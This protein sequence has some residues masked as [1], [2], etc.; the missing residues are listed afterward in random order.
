MGCL[1]CNIIEGKTPSKKVYE[2]DTVYAFED[3][4]PQAPVHVLVVHKRHTRSIDEI[5]EGNSSI[6]SDLFLAVKEVAR[7]TG[8]DRDGYRVI[9]N[10]GPAAG[11]V[12]WHLHVHVLGG[13][14]NLGPMLSED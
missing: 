12:I 8:T 5:D 13:Q 11:Q 4:N 1:F 7:L 14:A 3:I 6:M 9:I 2:N 10:N